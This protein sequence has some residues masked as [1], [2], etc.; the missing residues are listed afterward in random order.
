MAD[1]D[2]AVPAIH[3]WHLRS[4]LSTV[5]LSQRIDDGTARCGHCHRQITWN[6]LGG[7]IALGANRFELVCELADCLSCQRSN[8]R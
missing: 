2:D 3:D 1:L 6:S 8:H 7:I 4:V 5:G